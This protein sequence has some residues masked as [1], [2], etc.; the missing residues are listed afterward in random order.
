MADLINEKDTLNQGRVK[1][2]DSIEASGRAE[3]KSDQAV[4]DASRALSKSESTQTQLDTI[5]VEGDSSVEAAQARVDEDGKT[6]DTLKERIDSGFED[7][8]SKIE[9]NYEE[10]TS[11]LADIETDLS[12][13]AAN[14]KNYGAIGDGTT[15]DTA[16][17]QSAIDDVESAGGGIVEIPAGVFRAKGLIIPSNVTVRGTGSSTII[18]A[19]SPGGYLF[20]MLGTIDDPI[21]FSEDKTQGDSSIKTVEE[22]GLSVGDSVM[23]VS[24]RNCLSDD[25]GKRWRLGKPTPSVTHAFFGEFKDVHS[26]ISEK[27]FVISSA[28]HF[29][30][31]FKDK[32]RELNSY[33]SDSAV[34]RKV[35]F[36]KNARVENLQVSGEFSGIL[37]V[38]Y[39]KGCSI[40]DVEWINAHE[41]SFA[42][43]RESLACVAEG[44]VLEYSHK[45]EPSQ[46][47]KR[48]PLKAISSHLCGFRSC[49]M[50][51]ATQALDFTFD[52]GL[53]CSAYNFMDNCIIID[54]LDNSATSHGGTYASLFQNN[55]MTGC[56]KGISTRSRNS[57][58]TGN[59]IVGHSSKMGTYGVSIFDGWSRDTIVSNNT[60]IGFS[61]G[62]EITEGD[63]G[64]FDYNGAII[65]GNI[66][67]NSLN[68]VYVRRW[69]NNKYSGD[70][71]IKIMNNTLNDSYGYG[72]TSAKGIRVAPYVHG[73]TIDN[74]SIIINSDANGAIFFEENA[75]D[76]FI[77]DNK[78]TSSDGSGGRSIWVEQ[79]SDNA[80]FPTGRVKG[81]YSGNYHTGL[82]RPNETN[83]NFG[84]S[85][86]D[87]Y[88]ILPPATDDEYTLGFSSR[89]WKSLY[90]KTGTI[91]TSDARQ[92][93]LISEIPDEWL[94]AWA[95]VNYTRFKFNSSINEKGEN[96][97]WHVGVIAQQVYDA[98]D[99]RGLD[100][101][102]I[103]LLCYDEWEENG[104]RMDIWS[105]RPDESH[106][107][108]TALLRRE[109]NQLKLR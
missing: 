94:D 83:V 91:Q 41:G 90:A 19:T 65:D 8:S 92:K 35:N 31:Y 86:R 39:G 50:I 3:E 5:V 82:V 58:I 30:D 51:N 26:L 108:E 16:S 97:R 25:A 15:N 48:N 76:F 88:G 80:L 72:G 32:T 102:E 22:H 71:N 21:P 109:L 53:I 96:A 61:N 77:T 95:D 44:L 75:S 62:I 20:Q 69:E 49:R 103:G 38:H 47:Y 59:F 17:I 43:F 66:V 11:Q 74:N 23:L 106:F 27:E 12:Q 60:I 85:N 56:R 89:R 68:G 105:I 33:A 67:Q 73:I 45:K 40:K 29:P 64:L 13:R 107:L 2:N 24:Q 63:G 36:V 78:L 10:T 9:D 98:F 46:H 42:V 70:S 52:T 37:N 99:K 81:Y 93:D 1:L 4:G 55:R 7:T 79:P 57:V 104:E 6:H 100:A 101:F 54:A 28:L 34:V 84:L 14:V 18:Q 87:I